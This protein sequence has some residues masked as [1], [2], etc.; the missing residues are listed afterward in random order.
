MNTKITLIT[1]LAIRGAIFLL[2]FIGIF[3]AVPSLLIYLIFPL[4]IANFALGFFNGKKSIIVNIFL[5]ALS[6]LLFIIIIDYIVT[7]IGTILSLV[8]FLMLLKEFKKPV[9]K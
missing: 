3:V 8:H 6:P 2:F 5:L 9:K 7:I 4:I 1:Q